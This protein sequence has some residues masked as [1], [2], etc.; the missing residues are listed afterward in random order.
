MRSCGLYHIKT[1]EP[2]VGFPDLSHLGRG[3]ADKDVVDKDLL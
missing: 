3:L 1:P 2:E